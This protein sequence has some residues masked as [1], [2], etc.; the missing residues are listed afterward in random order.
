M[1]VGFLHTMSHRMCRRNTER[2]SGRRLLNSL[3]YICT[4]EPSRIDQLLIRAPIRTRRGHQGFRLRCTSQVSHGA[5]G[6]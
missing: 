2:T 5:G 1:A 6:H 3:R 4:V